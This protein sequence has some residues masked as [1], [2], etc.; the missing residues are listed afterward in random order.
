MRVWE[1]EAVA[2]WNTHSPLDSPPSQ[3]EDFLFLPSD[4]HRQKLFA[5][6]WGLLCLCSV[7][8]WARHTAIG[9][10]EES[11]TRA[12]V[13]NLSQSRSGRQH[14]LLQGH[15]LCGQA[16]TI[17]PARFVFYMKGC[18]F[19]VLHLPVNWI[20]FPSPKYALKVCPI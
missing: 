13:L 12:L 2:S 1:T 15:F 9:H 5:Q 3:Q 18:L 4:L 19:F 8:L 6:G 11:D 10:K 20:V 7:S 17:P 14:A 16:H